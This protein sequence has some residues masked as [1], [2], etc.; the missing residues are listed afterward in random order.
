MMPL[1][2]LSEAPRVGVRVAS[3]RTSFAD[4]VVVIERA[5]E[6]LRSVMMRYPDGQQRYDSLRQVL[7][8]NLCNNWGSVERSETNPVVAR[9]YLAISLRFKNHMLRFGEASFHVLLLEFLSLSARFDRLSDAEFDS[10][11]RKFFDQYALWLERRLN[12][13]PVPAFRLGM[14]DD[15]MNACTAQEFIESQSGS[16]LPR[17]HKEV[18]QRAAAARRVIEAKKLASTPSAR[19]KAFLTRQA[20]RDIKLASVYDVIDEQVGGL[21]SFLPNVRQDELNAILTD[22]KDTVGAVKETVLKNSDRLSATLEELRAA[23]SQINTAKP[24]ANLAN[25]SKKVG[26]VMDSLKGM[27]SK[28]Q[29]ILQQIYDAVKTWVPTG[30]ALCIVA[31]LLYWVYART[32]P[33]FIVFTGVSVVASAVLGKSIWDLVCEFFPKRAK[34]PKSHTID[35]D[36]VE[37]QSGGS[38]S[39]LSKLVATV[40]VAHGLDLQTLRQG[41]RW[42]VDRLSQRIS[43]APKMAA[44]MTEIC[45]WVIEAFRS[46]VQGA[47]KLFGH[48]GFKC[49]QRAETNV[50]AILRRVHALYQEHLADPTKDPQRRFVEMSSCVHDLFEL[51]KLYHGVKDVEMRL[52]EATRMLA[53]IQGPIRATAAL[54]AGFRPEP[55]TFCLQ[56][57]PGVG[58]TTMFQWMIISIMSLAEI[59]PEGTSAEAAARLI[60]S[61]AWNTSYWEGYCD[62]PVV[63]MDDFGLAKVA[64]GEESNCYLDLATAVGPV[65]TMVNMAACENK[66]M[67]SMN[68]RLLALTTNVRDMVSSTSSALEA[69]EAIVRR[70]H[71]PYEVRVREEFRLQNSMRLDYEKFKVERARCIRESDGS[72]FSKFPWHMWQFHRFEFNGGYAHDS[73]VSAEELICEIVLKM[74]ANEVAHADNVELMDETLRLPRPDPMKALEE[75]RARR[76]ASTVETQ[77]GGPSRAPSFEEVAAMHDVIDI[78]EKILNKKATGNAWP[79]ITSNPGFFCPCCNRPEHFLVISGMF[80]LDKEEYQKYW[81]AELAIHDYDGVIE[82]GPEDWCM[83]FK[84]CVETRKYVKPWTPPPPPESESSG[85]EDDYQSTVSYFNKGLRR[86][87][88]AFSL[89]DLDDSNFE[90]SWFGQTLNSIRR[91]FSRY[92]RGARIFGAIGSAAL[93]AGLGVLTYEAIK[94]ICGLFSSFWTYMKSFFGG[95]DKIEE[96][97]N[98]TVKPK[99]VKFEHLRPKG[100]ETQ[101]GKSPDLANQVYDNSFKLVVNT[102]DG[103]IFLR[104]G[105]FL[106]PKHFLTALVGHQEE[107]EISEMSKISLR[108]CVHEELDIAGGMTV[109][110]FMELPR[111]EVPG[112]DIALCVMK[113]VSPKNDIVKFLIKEEEL[114]D[115]CNKAVRLDT[116][117][118]EKNGVLVPWNQRLAFLD[119]H[120]SYGV[121]D[122]YAASRFSTTKHTRWFRYVALTEVGDCGAPLCLQRAISFQHRVWLGIHVGGRENNGYAV[123]VTA[124]LVEEGLKALVAKD[125]HLKQYMIKQCTPEETD[126]QCGIY[127]KRGVEF[128]PTSQF[129]FGDEPLDSFGSFVAVAKV[130]KPV[131]TPS[132]SKLVKTVAGREELF[133]KTDQVRM[134]MGPYLQDDKMVYPMVQALKPY[135]SPLKHVDKWWTR[136]GIWAGMSKFSECSRNV[137]GRVLTYK[138]AVVGN[139][140]LG[141]KSIP[142]HSSVGYPECLEAKDK[143]YY[144]GNDDEY[145]LTTPNAIQLEKEVAQLEGMI[146]RGERPYFVC[147]GFLKDETRK[148][149]KDSRYIAGT[150]IHYYILCRKYFGV[151]VA[152]QMYQHMENG[153]CPG[154]R[155]FKDWPWLRGWVTRPGGKCWDGDFKGFDSSQMPTFL[156]NVLDYINEWYTARGAKPEENLARAVLFQDLMYSRHLVGRGLSMDTVVNFSKS[157]PSGHFLTAFVNSMQSMCYIACAYVAITFRI[158]FWEE[159]ATATLGDDNVNGAS[160][161]IIEEFNQVSLAE[162]LDKEMGLKYTSAR[163]DGILKPFYD[164]SQCEFLKRSFKL[165]DGKETCPLALGSI[166]HSMYWVRESRHASKTQILADMCENALGELSLHG[167]EVWNEW[168]PKV[169]RLIM[170]LGSY[171]KLPTDTYN[172]YL[173]YMLNRSD[174]SWS[175]LQIRSYAGFNTGLTD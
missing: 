167:G 33:S 157:L 15:E 159:C 1:Q 22:T 137:E 152:T 106:M 62:Q 110:E 6:V 161:Q 130:N 68:A 37:E 28:L 171:P 36:G 146:L 172:D 49:L 109:G 35:M 162:F 112:H 150:S 24:F 97:S 14:F 131:S 51:R 92:S 169:R 96:Q 80:G 125:P 57:V 135:A 88:I 43:N 45:S 55:V 42:V 133:G 52:S 115:T 38:S 100:V 2:S 47:C 94:F 120:V 118:V 144:W 166:L 76:M 61:K 102:F 67:Y 72:F 163:K 151:I 148:V 87:V 126:E 121:H 86:P 60:F 174:S 105:T 168:A 10:E 8:H 113:G 79:I 59:I 158:D 78:A 156:C 5:D 32:T 140:A 30:A 175:G 123:P 84:T 56:G 82:R 7:F 136:P 13:E 104:G 127:T 147:R 19:K 58:K 27:I 91:T 155:E 170:D 124:E 153:M 53:I 17:E 119:P 154:I 116:A 20:H 75:A 95:T 46:L 12:G 50:E 81:P 34:D 108:S 145:N 3:Q 143:S 69:P 71:F 141:L 4:A 73:W 160:D 40:F 16:K 164:I 114:R 132:H 85:S 117:R 48:P 83:N 98:R 29:T 139:T 64:P 21:L 54:K 66:G 25:A 107:A 26:S 128:T 122:L 41:D 129:P 77:S 74:K 65:K 101:A 103:I 39:A 93:I 165:L 138:E 18:L 149:G 99:A 63:A 89:A 11:F 44:G 70:I 23:A 111:Y 9:W 134:R 90:T 173:K 31:S 142:R